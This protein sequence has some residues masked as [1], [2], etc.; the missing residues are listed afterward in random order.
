M[1]RVPKSIFHTGTAP[2]GMNVRKISERG[3]RASGKQSLARARREVWDKFM[4][5]GTAS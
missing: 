2:N 1:G 3:A 5:F 4:S